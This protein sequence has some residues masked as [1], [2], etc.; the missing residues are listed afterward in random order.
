M[1]HRQPNPESN[2]ESNLWQQNRG[3][4]TEII[5]ALMLFELAIKKTEEKPIFPNKN[6]NKKTAKTLGDNPQKKE[7][8]KKHQIHQPQYSSRQRMFEG[9]R[10]ERARKKDQ[11]HNQHENS[12]YLNRK[13]PR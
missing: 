8:A 10:S 9:P 7:P 6:L 1:Q 3:S 13:K 5:T 4:S 12:T 11:P 2:P